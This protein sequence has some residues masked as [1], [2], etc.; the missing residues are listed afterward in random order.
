MNA[1]CCGNTYC[2]QNELCFGTGASAKCSS[3]KG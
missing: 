3:S 1:L 2:N